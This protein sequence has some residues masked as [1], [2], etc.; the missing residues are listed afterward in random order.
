MMAAS[1]L[2]GSEACAGAG[3]RPPENSESES[4]AAGGAGAGAPAL[5]EAASTSP[6]EL[7][8]PPWLKEMMCPICWGPACE[9]VETTC[10]HHVFCAS[11]MAALSPAATCPLCKSSGRRVA[12]HA[13]PFARRLLDYFPL[14]CPDACGAKFKPSEASAHRT[15]CSHA[16]IKCA[17]CPWSG[18]RGVHR[19]HLQTTHAVLIEGPVTAPGTSGGSEG[20]VLT[21]FFV[22]HASYV[23]HIKEGAPHL[24]D[25]FHAQLVGSWE[26]EVNPREQWAAFSFWAMPVRGGATAPP[27]AT[28]MRRLTLKGNDRWGAEHAVT[29]DAWAEPGEGRAE[30]CVFRAAGKIHVTPAVPASVDRGVSWCGWFFQEAF[31][32]PLG[33][34]NLLG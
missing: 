28:G 21:Q 17:L 29:F 24:N 33:A 12:Y 8:E 10:C 4:A 32:V 1:L 30:V 9:A 26:S 3:A 5:A 25:D 27:P 6:S 20:P 19:G 11:C 2:T 31:F 16:P 13:S 18:T 22:T 23:S 14:P 7:P 15:S 34:Y